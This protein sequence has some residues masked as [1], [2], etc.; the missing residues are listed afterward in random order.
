MATWGGLQ[1]QV[2]VYE[3]NVKAL[4]QEERFSQHGTKD[5]FGL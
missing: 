4:Q 3:L 1:K 5:V 2:N